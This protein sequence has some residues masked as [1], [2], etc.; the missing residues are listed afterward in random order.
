MKFTHVSPLLLTHFNTVDGFLTG[1]KFG[2]GN[3]SRSDVH[4]EFSPFARY[5]FSRKAFNYSGALEVSGGPKYQKWAFVAEGGKLPEQL[6]RNNPIDPTINDMWSLLFEQNFMKIYERDYALLAFQK[7]FSHK[8]EMSIQGEWSNNTMLSN[9]TDFVIFNNKN[10]SYTSN[11]PYNA[12]IGDTEFPDYKATTIEL[13]AKFKPWARFRIRNGRK[14]LIDKPS[15]E[16]SVNIKYAIPDVFGSDV[17]YSLIDVGFTH[18]VTFPAGGILNINLGGGIFMHG[19]AEYFPEFAHFNGSQLPFTT[20]DPVGRYRALEYYS[21]STKD[22]YATA[23]L[24]YQFRKLL[25]TQLLEVRLTGAKEG[26]FL[27][28]L[29][30]PSSDH[31]FE[32]GYGLN[33]IFRVLRIELVTSFQDFRYTGFGVRV[34]V[35]ANLET[36]FN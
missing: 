12:E 28:V 16:F 18:V 29:E 32:V 1:L 30:T 23:H 6:N 3:S 24:F 27:S 19:D 14:S 2:L 21:F 15:P 10:R 11:T 9:T 13:G 8:L 31:Y 33:Y 4:W 35:A 20:L 7:A 25:A 5:A 26:I 17:D 34:G 36:L 22:K